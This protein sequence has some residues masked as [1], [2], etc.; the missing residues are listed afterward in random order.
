MVSGSSFVFILCLYSFKNR[1]IKQGLQVTG[2]GNAEDEEKGEKP[3]DIP[4]E[5]GDHS[6]RQHQDRPGQAGDGK[7]GCV[8]EC[9]LCRESVS[10]S[11]REHVGRDSPCQESRRKQGDQCY[12]GK[13]YSAADDDPAVRIQEKGCR[14]KQKPERCRILQVF[15]K[16]P[17][18]IPFAAPSAVSVSTF[19]LAFLQQRFSAAC[20]HVMVL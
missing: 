11:Q 13:A 19:P 9:V 1:Q 4:E 12:A 3:G 7:D 10:G 5:P 17:P 14:Q 15:E 2:Q 16:S 18:V 6:S 20:S 8:A